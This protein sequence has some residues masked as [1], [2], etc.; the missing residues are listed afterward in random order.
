M[1]LASAWR[2]LVVH[3][4][5]SLGQRPASAALPQAPLAGT[6]NDP[7]SV[8]RGVGRPGDRHI[9]GRAANAERRRLYID[10]GHRRG[11][12]LDN[13]GS[14]IQ[15]PVRG[16]GRW[17]GQLMA[18]VDQAS[19]APARDR[20]ATPLLATIG[21]TRGFLVV[22]GAAPSP[23]TASSSRATGV[24][25]KNRGR[26]SCRFRAGCSGVSLEPNGG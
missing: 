17:N 16:P 3:G 9:L 4:P 6:L 11:G 1:T 25:C 8:D 24:V 7:S 2:R 12:F 15:S 18:A 22:R 26:T 23:F 19:R 20:A 5:T 21:S 10:P 14:S 13:G